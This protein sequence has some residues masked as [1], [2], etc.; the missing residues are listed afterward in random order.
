MEKVDNA[1]RKHRKFNFKSMT[2]KL[3]NLNKALLKEYVKNNDETITDEFD[4]H[5]S[6]FDKFEKIDSLSRNNSTS[7]SVDTIDLV[8]I[9]VYKLSLIY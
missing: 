1:L 3:N 6:P 8:Y 5:E 4:R 2:E 9:F 7:S